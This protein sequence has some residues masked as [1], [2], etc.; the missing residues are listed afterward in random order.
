MCG[1]ALTSIVCPAAACCLAACLQFGTLSHMPPCLLREGRLT[2]RADVYAFSMVMW[3]LFT[4]SGW[5]GPAVFFKGSSA[6]MDRTD[7][8]MWMPRQAGWLQVLHALV[9]CS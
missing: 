7:A 2:T 5:W 4:V 6:A 9:G 3:Q 8:L 1:V